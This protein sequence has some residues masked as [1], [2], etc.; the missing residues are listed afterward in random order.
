MARDEDLESWEGAC[1]SSRRKEKRNLPI[2]TRGCST[3]AQAVTALLR[4]VEVR[5]KPHL[6]RH[7]NWVY[8][9]GRYEKTT[10]IIQAEAELL[11]TFQKDDGRVMARDESRDVALSRL[12][13]IGRGRP[14]KG[15]PFTVWSWWELSSSESSGW[16]R[17]VPHDQ[18]EAVERERDETARSLDAANERIAELER[19]IATL[20]AGRDRTNGDFLE[21]E[22]WNAGLE[23]QIQ[24]KDRHILELERL[25]EA[26]RK[27][28]DGWAGGAD[29]W[30]PMQELK[31]AIGE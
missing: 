9:S 19:E 4:A 22:Q 29:V 20:K 8:P 30:G 26:A 24:S 14:L 31:K 7:Q 2:L 13:D 28:Y 21:L 25:R 17:Y 6:D 15:G 27:A 1:R 12:L 16:V 5:R 3:V 10:S 11:S 18:L 23:V